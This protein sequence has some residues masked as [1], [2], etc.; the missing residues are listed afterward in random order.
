[1]KK[2]IVVLLAAALLTGC[3]GG[4]KTGGTAKLSDEE[5]ETGVIIEDEA[6]MQA[7]LKE[8][9]ADVE[10]YSYPPV[11]PEYETK[12]QEVYSRF[13]L[14]LVNRTITEDAN[15]ISSPLSVYS[16]LAMLS[17][18]AAGDTAEQMNE[19]LGMT[20]EELNLALYRLFLKTDHSAPEDRPDM[21]EYYRQTVFWGNALWL[22]SGAGFEVNENYRKVLQG[23]YNSDII[24]EDFADKPAVVQH[25]ND[26]IAEHTNH[27]LENVYSEDSLQDGTL[28]LLI[29]SLAFE[30]RWFSE[31]QP[32]DNTDETFHNQDGSEVT[33]AMMHCTEM[34]WW[35]DDHAQGI[36]KQLKQGGEVVLILPEEGMSVYDY[37]AQM[38]PDTFRNLPGEVVYADN[39]TDTTYDEHYT[40]LT[41]PKF[42]YD[43]DLDLGETLKEMGLTRIFDSDANLS[44]MLASDYDQLFIS[45]KV[46]HKATVD[47]N[48][49]GISAAVATIV[50]GLGSAGELRPIPVYH[51]LTLD[52]PFIYAIVDAGVPL[53]IGV[54]SEMDG[55]ILSGNGS[56][57]DAIGTV[58]VKVEGLRIRSE[59]GTWSEPA[60]TVAAGET[61]TVYETAEGQGYTWYRIGSRQWIADKGGD[62]LEYHAE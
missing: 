32:S 16:A 18:A 46:I 52:R 35:H 25:V 11:I 2:K 53:F 9:K 15:Y 7:K 5:K 50:G 37:L 22:N 29:N 28:F 58:T 41:I 61:R 60:G 40:D 3:A 10:S 30:D 42:K 44:K 47:L 55:T 54:V 1:M 36:F 57:N 17:N 33:T 26:W 6:A 23:Y 21:A 19:V 27:M 43:A 31:F 12:F 14:D 49:E 24:G 4:A 20:P 48:E 13:A 34:G 39:Y 8:V 62:W 45:D 51:E 59:P 38:N 56:A